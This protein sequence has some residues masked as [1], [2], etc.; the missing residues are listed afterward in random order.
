MWLCV[1][2]HVCVSVYV[3]VCACICTHVRVCVCVCACVYVRVRLLV[4]VCVCACVRLCVCVCVSLTALPQRAQHLQ[5]DVAPLG[6]GGPAELKD[7]DP[8]HLELSQRLTGRVWGGREGR[9]G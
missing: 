4:S 1:P 3:Y 2:V 5:D 8:R 7:Q 6:V 9:L